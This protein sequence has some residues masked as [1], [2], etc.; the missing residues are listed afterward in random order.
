[1]RLYGANGGVAAKAGC[2]QPPMSVFFVALP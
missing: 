2:N 1:M